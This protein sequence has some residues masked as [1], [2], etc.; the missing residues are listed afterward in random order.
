M[1]DKTEELAD[2]LSWSLKITESDVSPDA[3]LNM[4][5]VSH[6][7][8]SHVFERGSPHSAEIAD[9]TSGVGII[10]QRRRASA[11]FGLYFL[12]EALTFREDEYALPINVTGALI[13][14]E[15]DLLAWINTAWTTKFSG[16]YLPPEKGSFS[17]FETYY[18][19]LSAREIT[20]DVQ[21]APD[22]VALNRTLAI[23]AR[24]IDLACREFAI[25]PDEREHA[26]YLAGLIDDMVR[27]SF[28]ED[29]V[30]RFS[31]AASASLK[32]ALLHA[33]FK[34][35]AERVKRREFSKEHIKS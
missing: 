4:L 20:D 2:L 15:K 14:S 18:S 12:R 9:L 24:L 34:D 23:F 6:G 35:M 19:H 16:R 1:I 29:I 8:V 33:P 21:H 30:K 13:A 11:R 32:E 28:P 27:T 22:M 25:T 5:Q 7:I 26:A 3:Y 10:C 31:A 17:D